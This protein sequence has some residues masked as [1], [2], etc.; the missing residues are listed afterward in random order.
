MAAQFGRYGRHVAAAAVLSLA[1]GGMMAMAQDPS[2]P[3]APPADHHGMGMHDGPGSHKHH[4]EMMTK[5]LNLSPDQVTQVKAIEADTM[6]QAKA[7]RDDTTVSA[8]DRHSKMRE[9]HEGAMTKIRAVLN[10]EQKAKFD[11][12]QAHHKEHMEHGNGQAPPPPPPA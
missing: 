7:M 3:P 4:M 10:D 1:M 11:A 6:A 8:A 12:M 5:H 9:L 2:G